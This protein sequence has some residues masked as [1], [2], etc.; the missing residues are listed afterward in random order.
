[1]SDNPQPPES[2]D[3]LERARRNKM[4]RLVELGV[5]PW[6]GRFDD[7]SLIGDIRSRAGELKYVKQTEEGAAGEAIDLPDL[8]SDPELKQKFQQWLADQGKG[9][10]PSTISRELRR[11]AATRSGNLNYRAITAQWHADQRARRP[12]V[13]TLAANDS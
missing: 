2:D 1:M 5:D 10:T 12:K 11:N 7:R 9:Q 8:D 4:Q 3:D 13:A 6:G